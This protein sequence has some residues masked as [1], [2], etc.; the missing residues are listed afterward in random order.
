MTFRL[1]H[2]TNHQGLYIRARTSNRDDGLSRPLI[3][4]QAMFRR[5]FGRTDG[6]CRSF[7]DRIVYIDNSDFTKELF[8]DTD[9]S[10]WHLYFVKKNYGYNRH[11]LFLNFLVSPCDYC[12]EYLGSLRD[13]SALQ[14]L[15]RLLTEFCKEY[16]I[17]ICS[18]AIH[19]H[20]GLEIP[21]V[22]TGIDTQEAEDEYDEE[23]WLS[24]EID[25]AVDKTIEHH[26]Q[27]KYEEEVLLSLEYDRAVDEAIEHHD[28]RISY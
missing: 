17:Q 19:L 3:W 10:N 28:E 1:L 15:A 13:A 7:G 12:D 24:V 5:Q 25:R 6:C 22:R 20:V 4:T 26:E 21:K 27:D 2:R 8:P 18:N 14:D 11:H 16:E 23:V 9:K